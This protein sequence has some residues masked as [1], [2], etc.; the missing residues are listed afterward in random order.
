MHLFLFC[1]LREACEI[2]LICPPACVSS[3]CVN[4]RL[5]NVICKQLNQ[6]A[7]LS[8]NMYTFLTFGEGNGLILP[9]SITP[10]CDIFESMPV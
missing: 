10:I 3:S 4:L 9:V 8:T 5:Q 2:T 6:F 7:F 1:F